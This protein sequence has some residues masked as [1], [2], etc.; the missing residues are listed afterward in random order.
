MSTHPRLEGLLRQKRDQ[1]RPGTYANSP[2]QSPSVKFSIL[3]E[4][5]L[6]C[7]FEEANIQAPWSNI[8]LKQSEGGTELQ[9]THKECKLI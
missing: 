9:Q 5:N 7:E 8:I 1:T 4:E 2:G 6:H 3:R